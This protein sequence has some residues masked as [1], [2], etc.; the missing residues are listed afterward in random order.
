[1]S[2]GQ[3]A[4]TNDLKVYQKD[5]FTGFRKRVL[6]NGE[7]YVIA[8]PS[9][10]H[11]IFHTLDVEVVSTPWYSALI[12]AKQLS[13]YYF[14]LSEALGYHDHLPRYMSLPL[15]SSLDN[16][17]E[18]APYGG[19]PRPALIVDRLRGEFPQRIG[20]QWSKFY[21]TRYFPIDNPAQVTP[22]PRWWEE[23]RSNWEAFYEPHRL[24]FVVDQYKELIRETECVTGKTFDHAVFVEQMHRINQLCALVDEAKEIIARAR[25]CP[26][27]LNEQMTNI[28]GVTWHRGSQW[29][30]D[31]M[32]AYIAELR[33]MVDRGSA[34]CPGE[35]VRLLWLNNGLWF[36]TG[37]YRAF[38]EKHGAVF[39]WSM[40]TNYLS[41]GYYREFERDPLR[42]LASRH[43]SANDQLHLPPWMADWII[44]QARDFGAHGAVMLVPREDRMSGWGTK[45]CARAL[46]AAGIPVVMLEGNAVDAR[47]WD[48]EKMTAQVDTFIESRILAG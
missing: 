26:V 21:G 2:G 28:M 22:G 36:N 1:M 19:L 39:V 41:D 18:R 12:A 16:N 5:W 8:E 35:K 31:H 42:A 44:Q 37:F 40:Y 48:N 13:P 34:A 17:P 6:E 7:P 27:S 11:E 25:P 32:K 46:E 24:D 33:A 23:S 14:D 43:I 4:V 10:P 30:L 47:L 9:T 38:E 3:M 15:L 45:L 20:E 29:A